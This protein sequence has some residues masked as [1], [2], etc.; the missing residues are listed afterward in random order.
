M[1]YDTGRFHRLKICVLL[2][3][4]SSGPYLEFIKDEA[5]VITSDKGYYY[6][7]EKSGKFSYYPINCT[8]IEKIADD[9]RVF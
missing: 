3:N 8:I 9:E 1:G 6:I 7:H 5:D 4:G 2:M